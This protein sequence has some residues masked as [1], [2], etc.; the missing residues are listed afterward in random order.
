MLS[1]HLTIIN[2]FVRRVKTKPILKPEGA[3]STKFT[4]E[5][6]SKLGQATSN[7]RV[8]IGEAFK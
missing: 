5:Q 1:R 4:Q 8:S 2:L 3:E 6:L 7:A